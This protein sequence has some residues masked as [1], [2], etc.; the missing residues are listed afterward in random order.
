MYEMQGKRTSEQEEHGS[1]GE[2]EMTARQLAV[3]VAV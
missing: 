2:R 1:P 3:G